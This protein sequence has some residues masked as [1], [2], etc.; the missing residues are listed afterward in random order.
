MTTSGE[1]LV[2]TIYNCNSQSFVLWIWVNCPS[3]SRGRNSKGPIPK[4]VMKGKYQEPGNPSQRT[5]THDTRV[6]VC[7]CSC[8][9]ISSIHPKHYGIYIWYDTFM[10]LVIQNYFLERIIFF[11]KNVR[12]FVYTILYDL[13]LI[14]LNLFFFGFTVSL[15]SREIAQSFW[16]LINF[17]NDFRFEQIFFHHTVLDPG[18][19][20]LVFHKSVPVRGNLRG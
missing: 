15:R 8:E 3:R 19:L 12:N 6:I 1:S 20:R 13:Y 10:T 7:S 2:V 11:V 5:E 9:T 14:R 4:Q 17:V 18:L 16:F